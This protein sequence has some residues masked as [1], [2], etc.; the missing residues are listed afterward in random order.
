MS[1]AKATCF[2]AGIVK[3]LVEHN[4]PY[5]HFGSI[6]GFMFHAKVAIDLGYVSV[7]SDEDGINRFTVTKEGMSY[8][9][10]MCLSSL[11]GTRSYFWNNRDWGGG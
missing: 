10:S 8:Y 1:H 2:T 4:D 5:R 7:V 3:G 11:E 9:T 6:A